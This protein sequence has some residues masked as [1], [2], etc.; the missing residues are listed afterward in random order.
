MQR[1][2]APG[3]LR[4]LILEEAARAGVTI[5][6]RAAPPAPD[7]NP[8]SSSASTPDLTPDAKATARAKTA[9]REDE[10]APAALID[11]GAT[12]SS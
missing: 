2:N 3:T 4:R 1:F 5:G 11:P 7:I 8:D 10:V 9:A 6:W 12:H